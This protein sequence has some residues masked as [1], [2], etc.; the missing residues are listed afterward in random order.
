MKLTHLIL[1]GVFII[2]LMTTS[3]FASSTE[4]ANLNKLPSTVQKL[5]KNYKIPEQS[6]SLFIKE[7]DQRQPLMTLNADIPRNPASTIKIITTFAGLE[8]LGPTYSWQTKFYLDGTLADYTLD[9]NLVMQGGGDPFLVSEAFWHILFTLQAKGLKHINGDL[10]IDDGEFED[11]TGSPADFDNKPYRAYNVFPDAALVNFRV[12]QFNFVPQKDS[13]HIYADPPAATMKINNKVKLTK[14]RCRGKHR[15][16]KHDVVTHGHQTLITFTGDYPRSCG[17]QN[18]LRTIM[19]NDQYVFGV[20]KSLWENMGGTITGTVGKTR[21]NGEK[22]FYVA[23]SR[24]L[25]EIITY[26]NKYSNNVMARQLLLTIGKEM[27]ESNGKDKGSKTLG[28]QAIKEWLV[29]IG[30]PAPE[31]VLDN[32][33]GLS[34]K[35]SVS[36][37]TMGALLEHAYHS[38]Y[39][40]EFMASLPMLGIDGTVRK[41]LNGAVPAGEIRI[42][43][44]LLNDVRAMA[45]YVRSQSDKHYVVVSLQNYPGIQNGVGTQVQD[46]ILKWLYNQ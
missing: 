6:L 1:S 30:I 32:G 24:P 19:P 8:L 25:T 34:R 16:I 3:H 13:L 2:T 46:E 31:L 45:G 38:P 20:F 35:S 27:Q 15:H 41:R 37:A 43:T 14:G 33:S 18:L 42:K 10:L 40:P 7:I 23:T 4:I 22:P 28:R 44:G 12:H 36:A 39:Q 26:I 9:G 21:I 11:E 17:H 29:S 5:L